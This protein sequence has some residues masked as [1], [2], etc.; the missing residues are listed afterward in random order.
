MGE[1]LTPAERDE[2]L[3]GWKDRARARERVL[4]RARAEA[5]DKVRLAARLVRERYGVRRAVLF[6]SLVTGPFGEDSD[7]DLCV[8]GLPQSLYYPLYGDL[9]RVL[10]P[11]R[12]HL[13]LWEDLHESEAD[14]ALRQEIEARGVELE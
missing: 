14:R 7:I 5:L 12:L 2:Y 1:L 4:E 10:L 11:R 13:V 3:R 9:E 8:E 6:G